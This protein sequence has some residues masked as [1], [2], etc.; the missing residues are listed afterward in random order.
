MKNNTKD[1]VKEARF[2][3][4]SGRMLVIDPCFLED[5]D[6]APMNGAF[7]AEREISRKV[8]VDNLMKKHQESMKHLDNLA[9]S[10]NE[11]VVN[12]K[13]NHLDSLASIGHSETVKAKSDYFGDKKPRAKMS[14]PHIYQA[15]AYVGFQNSIGDGIYPL[16]QRKRGLHLVF[17]YPTRDLGKGKF[18]V[19]VSRLEGKLIGQSDV[20]GGVQIIGDA[21]DFNV[22]NTDK[23][24]YCAVE[25]PNGDYLCRFIKKNM[26]LSIASTRKA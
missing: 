4:H 15:Q 19:D 8:F 18:D 16:V 2:T 23:S 26:V 20:E 3:I 7:S 22:G 24:L 10:L 25:V 1:L 14:P 11:L 12:K 9:S 13:N 5:F 6:Y 21:A 17:N